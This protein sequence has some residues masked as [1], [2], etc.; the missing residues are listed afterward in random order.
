MLTQ[1]DPETNFWRVVR[2]DT[3][4]VTPQEKLCSQIEIESAAVE[5]GNTK[6][7]IYLYGLEHYYISTNHQ[8]FTAT[9]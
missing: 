2:Y 9:C 4:P 5:Y 7:H 8:P 1:K 3:R 6:Y